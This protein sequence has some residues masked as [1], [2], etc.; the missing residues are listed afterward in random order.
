MDTH[1]DERLCWKDNQVDHSASQ[2]SSGFEAS[3]S[4][5]SRPMSCALYYMLPFLEVLLQLTKREG[6][7]MAQA[8][9]FP[10]VLFHL[11]IYPLQAAKGHSNPVV[12][13]NMALYTYGY[14]G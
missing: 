9:T 6:K 11:L 10:L 2:Y 4:I 13:G 12:C 5:V 1:E 7:E 8:P 14:W 3:I